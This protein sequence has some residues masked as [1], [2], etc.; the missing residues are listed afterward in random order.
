VRSNLPSNIP[1]T[2]Y[3]RLHPLGC[4]I[5]THVHYAQTEMIASPGSRGSFMA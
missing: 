4:F 3:S 2:D 5:D 1:I